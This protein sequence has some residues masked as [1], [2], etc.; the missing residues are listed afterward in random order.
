MTQMFTRLRP[1]E[2]IILAGI[3]VILFPLFYDPGG[4][5]GHFSPDTLEFKSRSHRLLDGPTLRRNELTE[6]LIRMGHWKP[7]ETDNPRWIK[8]FEW[9][10]GQRDGYSHLCRELSGR[11]KEWIAWS[12]THPERAAVLWPQVLDML[13]ADPTRGAS[14]AEELLYATREELPFPIVEHFGQ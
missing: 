2:G 12:E 10:P 7:I 11:R 8:M 13:R 4:G 14:Q 6:Y 5:V 1:I 3:V 9:W